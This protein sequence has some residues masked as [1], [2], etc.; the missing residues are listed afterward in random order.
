MADAAISAMPAATVVNAADLLPVVQGGVNKRATVAVL[1]GATGTNLDYDASTRLLSSSTGSD[2]TLPLVASNA[3][4]MAP[5][6]GGGTANFLRADGTWAAPPS[7]GGTVT[8]VTGTAPI[9][10]ATGTSTPVVSITTATTGAAGAMAAADKAKLDG[11]AA[12]ATANAGTV[13]SVTGGAGLTGSVTTT[14]SLAVGA[15]TGITVSA[16]DVAVN[17]TVVDTWYAPRD[18][19]TLPAL[20]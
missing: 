13:T 20:P 12:G 9:Q 15:G 19:S 16:D 1:A 17:R 2:V 3:A 7:S 5:Q 8:N 11:I 4:G 14:G 10:V 6:S 18:L